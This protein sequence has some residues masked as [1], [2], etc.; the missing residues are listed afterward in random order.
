MMAGCWRPKVE[1][2][3]RATGCG[4]PITPIT[5]AGGAVG[6]AGS[7][8][9]A[10]YCR[11]LHILHRGYIL[12]PNETPSTLLDPLSQVGDQIAAFCLRLLATSDDAR[13]GRPYK[14]RDRHSGVQGKAARRGN[15]GTR[16]RSVLAANVGRRSDHGSSRAMANACGRSEMVAVD[17]WQ[18]APKPPPPSSQRSSTAQSSGPRSKQSFLN[19]ACEAGRAAFGT[20]PF[21]RVE[22]SFMPIEPLSGATS[23][24]TVRQTRSNTTPTYNLVAGGV[25]HR[26]GAMAT[27]PVPFPAS[28]ARRT[29]CQIRRRSVKPLRGGWRG[30]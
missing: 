30:D 25:I 26:R 24:H 27:G 4:R 29:T 2:S 20:A 11:L 3:I 10:K 5:G 16:A 18:I 19:L 13:T 15:L 9:S 22:A 1:P 21:R 8:C 17:D 12:K 14:I 7:T 23:Y 28:R 6:R